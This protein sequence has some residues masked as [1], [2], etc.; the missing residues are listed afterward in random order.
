M[1]KR[2]RVPGAGRKP[3]GPYANRRAGLTMR[4]SAELRAEL[5]RE[6]RR[7]GWSVSQEVENRLRESLNVAQTW[8]PPHT[9]ALARLV[10]EIVKRVELSAGNKLR[11]H[12]D[13]FVH[14]AAQEAIEALF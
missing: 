6:A 11:W 10:S 7:K 9:W 2:K 5:D 14:A 4:I 3:R 1:A 8:G 13:P 12:R